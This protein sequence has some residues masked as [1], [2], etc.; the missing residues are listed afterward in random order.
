[1]QKHAERESEMS[2]NNRGRNIAHDAGLPS[3]SHNHRAMSVGEVFS[4]SYLN[5]Q[6]I[7][8][9]YFGRFVASDSS[10]ASLTMQKTM[11]KKL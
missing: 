8:E 10:G 5:A 2:K 7:Y 4:V 1:M 6:K 11:T 3:S 9:F